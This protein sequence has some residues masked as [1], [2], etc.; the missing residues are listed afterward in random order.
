MKLRF[1]NSI[2]N[3]SDKYDEKS[4]KSRLNLLCLPSIKKRSAIL[5]VLCVMLIV[6]LINSFLD[7]ELCSRAINDEEKLTNNKDEF[8]RLKGI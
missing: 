1:S 5:Y 7:T 8:I 2:F 3:C 4:S 6:W